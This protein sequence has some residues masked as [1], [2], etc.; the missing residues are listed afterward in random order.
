MSRSDRSILSA[1]GSDRIAASP[2]DATGIGLRP[3]Q[4]LRATLLSRL[5]GNL[6]RL[7]AFGIT[8]DART[9]SH[10]EVGRTYD[11]RVAE[12][13]TSNRL[14]LELVRGGSELRRP[15]QGGVARFPQ[16]PASIWRDARALPLEL[17]ETPDLDLPD[18][19]RL[20]A[21]V[22]GLGYDL[23]AR[24]A[25]LTS[26]SERDRSAEVAHLRTTVKARALELVSREDQHAVAP[27]SAKRA[28]E[29]VES[30]GRLETENARRVDAGAPVVVP[31]PPAPDKGLRDAVMYLMPVFARQDPVVTE[32][33]RSESEAEA[34]RPDEKQPQ[35]FHAV[36]ILDFSGLG[37]LRVDVR[38]EL[39]RDESSRSRAGVQAA[40]HSV[41]GDTLVRLQEGFGALEGSLQALD[42]DVQSLRI[43]RV[44][45][46]I[47]TADLRSPPDRGKSSRGPF[48]VDLH[49]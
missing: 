35:E 41:L 49:A 46:E 2:T 42:L 37:P 36:L 43:H 15:A 18:S 3:G 20:A 23:E 12:S 29:L 5:G 11:L 19:R 22:R 33:R 48:A 6:I 26:L 16:H 34:S 40:F 30:L 21:S 10:L 1:V 28:A 4:S 32:D 9:T 14:V 17:G 27:E 13:S 31:L 39:P 38:V 47:P 44:E 8:F 24:V 7:G 45:G 25:R